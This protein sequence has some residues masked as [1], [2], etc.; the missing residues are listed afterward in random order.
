MLTVAASPLV[1]APAPDFDLR[2]QHGQHVRLSDL[3]GRPVVLV[4][5]PFAFTR[6]CTGELRA[7]RDE[8]A[9]L[10]A[11]VMAVSCD[12]MYALRVFAEQEGLEYPL[13]ADFW[14]HGEVAR[15]YGVF[16]AE[17]GCAKRG[18]FVIDGDGIVIWTVV[19]SIAE[20]R[21]IE[22]YRRVLQPA[23]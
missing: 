18:T 4:F 14:P 23:G 1:G 19:N 21:D 6:V 10:D 22:D 16:D 7:L 2:D 17:L 9:S 15:S 8:L 13:L 3:R 12:S 11:A 5:Y 20:A